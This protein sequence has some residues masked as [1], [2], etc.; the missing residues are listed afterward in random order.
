MKAKLEFD[1]P[2]EGA[3]YMYAIYGRNYLAVLESFSNELRTKYKHSDKQETT[4][5]EVRELFQNCLNDYN[6]VLFREGI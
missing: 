4:W 2:E 5:E 3:E 1:L 6:V